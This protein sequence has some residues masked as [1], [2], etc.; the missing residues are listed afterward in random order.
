MRPTPSVTQQFASLS[1]LTSSASCA[2]QL[3][4]SLCFSLS[5]SLP[6]SVSLGLCMCVA[7]C[8]RTTVA[9]PPARR[10]RTGAPPPRRAIHFVRRQPVVLSVCSRHLEQFLHDVVAPNPSVSRLSIAHH[11]HLNIVVSV[12]MNSV[13]KYNLLCGLLLIARVFDESCACLNVDRRCY[14]LQE[15]TFASP[16]L[17][18]RMDCPVHP[19]SHSVLFILGVI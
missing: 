16:H 17:S 7:R 4:L 1:F 2:F 18:T 15:H 3:L 13:C 6:L 9:V 8:S 5:L 10:G 19:Q 12:C 14:H 11:I